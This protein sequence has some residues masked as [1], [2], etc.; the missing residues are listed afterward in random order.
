M[1]G[2]KTVTLSL[3]ATSSCSGPARDVLLASSKLT[4]TPHDDPTNA[5]GVSIAGA[6]A[7]VNAEPDAKCKPATKNAYATCVACF[8][9]NDIDDGSGD[10]YTCSNNVPPLLTLSSPTYFTGVGQYSVT[11]TATDTRGLSLVCRM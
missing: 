4:Y 6:D 9:T 7:N 8:D 3:E 2:D 10:S 5:V 1:P 11:L